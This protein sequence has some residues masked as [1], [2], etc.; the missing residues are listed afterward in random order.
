[1]F[2]VLFVLVYSEGPKI[3]TVFE[4]SYFEHLS[5]DI[6]LYQS[7]ETNN[8]LIN[9]KSYARPSLSYV[10]TFMTHT[11]EFSVRPD[12]SFFWQSSEV[13]IYDK[14]LALPQIIT[15]S[16]PRQGIGINDA[17][18]KVLEENTSVNKD[19]INL[20][21]KI[22]TSFTVNEVVIAV[23]L[24]ESLNVDFIFNEPNY[25]QTPKLY[26][27][28]GVVDKTLGS[29]MISPGVTLNNF[30]LN[31]NASNELLSQ[32]LRC[33]FQS[34]EQLQSFIKISEDVKGVDHG[35][36]ISGDHISKAASFKALYE[37]LNILIIMLFVFVVIASLVIYF[38]VAYTSLMSI[39]PQA[40]LL[41]LLGAKK[42]DIFFIFL[43]LSTFN[44]IL[45]LGGVIL[46]PRVL[47]LISGLIHQILVLNL[48][49]TLNYNLVS[50]IVTGNYLLLFATITIIFLVNMRRPLLYL[51]IDG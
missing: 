45:G 27:P 11:G 47:P 18:L 25:F 14:K 13:T 20:K 51:L 21:L 23:N 39:L 26:L 16:E 1:M 3:I 36:E 6:S 49:F 48:S 12:Y 46:I 15:Y 8:D 32:K 41:K 30:L 9:V 34:N 2:L 44:F 33:H 35:I 24:S 38:V 17:Y 7:V 10:Q 42:S 5:V 28:Q 29:L 43:Y 22:N 37:Y 19:D 31:I 40:A 4:Q 50:L